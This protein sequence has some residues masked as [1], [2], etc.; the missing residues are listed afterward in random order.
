MLATLPQQNKVDDQVAA[1]RKAL[2]IAAA[3]DP[4]GVAAY[5]YHVHGQRLYPH[6]LL[7]CEFWR[8]LISGRL[9]N[10]YM[11]DKDGS[12]T[13]MRRLIVIMPTEHGK[14]ETINRLIEHHIGLHP[15]TRI[16]LVSERYDQATKFVGKI[17]RILKSESYQE[18]FGALLIGDLDQQAQFSVERPA[19]S[20]KEPTLTGSYVDGPVTGGHWPIRIYDDLMSAD[21]AR[22]P[23]AVR[24]AKAHYDDT[25]S[26]R[27][28]GP[29]SIE[30]SIGTRQG[31][32]DFQAHLLSQHAGV[33]LKTQALSEDEQGGAVYAEVLWPTLT[34]DGARSYVTERKLLHQRGPALWPEYRPLGG[35]NGLLELRRRNPEG[36]ERIQ[37]GNPTRREGERLKVSWFKLIA[38]TSVPLPE[39]SIHFWDTAVKTEARHDYSAGVQMWRVGGKLIVRPLARVKQP[40]NELMAT[41]QSYWRLYPAKLLLIE[42]ALHG[43][44]GVQH[45]RADDKQP[46]PVQG[47]PIKG[48][49]DVRL[50]YL[51]GY[52][53]PYGE[54][55]QV[56]VIDDGSGLAA[57]FIAEWCGYPYAAH[58][59][60]LAALIGGTEHLVAPVYEQQTDLVYY[61]P[62]RS[63]SVGGY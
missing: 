33:V 31:E 30:F 3:S 46:M 56:Y 16:L 35:Q 14:S 52:L 25:L 24:Q 18:V 47:H 28:D 5:T 59:D 12:P 9:A 40:F 32:D 44:V 4:R 49:L 17:R 11:V 13:I 7:L 48:S 53:A 20:G 55:P 22:S 2:L 1:E 63:L 26:T 10:P 37:Q 51:L 50:E 54:E 39:G 41:M 27:G 29:D 34:N 45:L 62:Q 8:L 21:A 61:R 43:G 38:P 42:D 6:Q 36:F 57:T 58:D 15:D 23:A 60:T 19:T